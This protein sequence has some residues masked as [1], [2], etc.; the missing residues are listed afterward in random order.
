MDNTLDDR[1]EKRRRRQA[2]RALRQAREHM[3]DP[4]AKLP[5]LLN[6]YAQLQ[7]R[8]KTRWALPEA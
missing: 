4:S 6:A 2:R 8:G 1:S 5:R 3:A 7:A